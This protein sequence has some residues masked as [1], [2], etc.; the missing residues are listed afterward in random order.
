[1]VPFPTRP[2]PRDKGRKETLWRPGSWKTTSVRVA[3]DQRWEREPK[4]MKQR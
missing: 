1:M 4:I 3:R 2:L